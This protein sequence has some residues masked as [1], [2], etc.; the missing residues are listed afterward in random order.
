MTLNSH[1]SK[2]VY[3]DCWITPKKFFD[4]FPRFDL[5]PCASDPMPWPSAQHMCTHSGLDIDWPGFAT[6]W[7]N[8]PYSDIGSWM[9]RLAEHGNGIALI[10]ARTET[11][12]FTESVWRK[13]SALYF[14]IGRPTFHRPDGTPGRGNSGYPCILA[15]YGSHCAGLLKLCGPRVGPGVY[16]TAWDVTP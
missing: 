16:M 4:A 12:W 6:V 7:L 15:A 1:H 5:D 14:L 11:Q 9:A 8:P 3:S 2:A 13:A 10:A